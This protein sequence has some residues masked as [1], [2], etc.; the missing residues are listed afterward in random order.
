VLFIRPEQKFCSFRF[1]PSQIPRVSR[2]Q[3]GQF[4]VVCLKFC[5]M[6]RYDAILLG[7]PLLSIQLKAMRSLILLFGAAGRDELVQ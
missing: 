6:V 4:R 2:D 7:L 1:P 3:I 5:S